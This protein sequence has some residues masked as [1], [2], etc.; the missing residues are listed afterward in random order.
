MGRAVRPDKNGRVRTF[1]LMLPSIATIIYCGAM[2]IASLVFP[3]DNLSWAAATNPD[4]FVAHAH[5]Q[6]LFG[7]VFDAILFIYTAFP[8]MSL[9]LIARNK[10]D[11]R[12]PGFFLRIWVANIVLIGVACLVPAAID[13]TFCYTYLNVGLSPATQCS[14]VLFA[15]SIISYFKNHSFR[16]NNSR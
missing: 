4:G 13:T 14:I 8:L 3:I 11:A 10:I 2:L 9:V 7:K 15:F 1:I 16:C 5:V 6:M 12:S